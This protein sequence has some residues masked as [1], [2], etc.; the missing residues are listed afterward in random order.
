VA[1][2]KRMTTLPIPLR[3]TDVLSFVLGAVRPKVVICA[4]ADA[5]KAVQYMTLP[6]HPRVLNV[7]HFIYWGKESERRLAAKVNRLLSSTR[8]I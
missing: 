8:P 3:T 1:Y 6:W 2:S 7:R 4:G 5:A